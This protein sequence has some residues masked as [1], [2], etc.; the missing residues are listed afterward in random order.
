MRYQ[1]KWV[2][3]M[4]KLFSSRL[5]SLIGTCLLAGLVLGS[6]GVAIA[7]LHLSQAD[8]RGTSQYVG[9]APAMS[10]TISSHIDKLTVTYTLTMRNE[11][12]GTICKGTPITFTDTIP[13]G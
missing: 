9:Q 8:A 11:A 12:H 5:S 2:S 13:Q 7:S 3:N 6:R 1:T 10:I 4:L